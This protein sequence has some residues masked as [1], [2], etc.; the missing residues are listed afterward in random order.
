MHETYLSDLNIKTIT[1]SQFVQPEIRLG[2]LSHEINNKK[3]LL[4][5]DILYYYLHK[6]S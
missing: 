1:G 3:L 2:I 4:D 5:S 6:Y